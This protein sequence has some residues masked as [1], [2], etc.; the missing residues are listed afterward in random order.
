M[1]N[2]ITL[3]AD[4]Q[5]IKK[6][7]AIVNRLIRWYEDESSNC[8][9]YAL[10]LGLLKPSHAADREYH[11]RNEKL[12]KEHREMQA[13][14]GEIYPTLALFI[15][16]CLSSEYVLQ[17]DELREAEM[18]ALRNMREATTNSLLTEHKSGHRIE[19][20]TID[21][22]NN[23]DDA[24]EK[25]ARLFASDEAGEGMAAFAEKRK[26]NFTGH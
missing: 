3:D 17:C 2:T 12:C 15:R 21:Q 10:S 1:G 22:E 23:A 5:E 8:L 18:A 20:I 16:D 11:Q 4:P 26:A 19:I 25:I 7:L 14:I 6:Y 9:S 24:A 13:V